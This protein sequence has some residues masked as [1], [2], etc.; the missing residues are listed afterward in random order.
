[1][2]KSTSIAN[3]LS[4][5][6]TNG[7][8]IVLD[9]AL[10]TYLELLG[11]DIS[12]SL[13]S[14]DILIKNPS[15]IKQAHLD[16]FRAGANIAIT[17]SYQASLPGL[18]KHLGDNE[19]QVKYL[20]GRSVELANDARNAYVD[21]IIAEVSEKKK[22]KITENGG[23]MATYKESIRCNLFIAGS[24]GPYG[25]FLA[26][27]SEYRGNYHV[28]KDDMKAFHRGRM[29]ELIHAGVDVLAIETIPSR[30]ETEALIELLQEEF[31]ETE[32]WFAFTLRDGEHIADGTGLV[33]MAALFDDVQQVV[34]LGFNCVPDDLAL[35]ALKVLAPR[36]RREILVV[37]PNSGEQWNAEAREWEGDRTEGC[38]L[39][40]KTVQ[41][42]HA[43]ARLI[44]GC[45][46]T[47]PG[48]IKIMR[49]SLQP[50]R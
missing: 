27:G 12:G 47:T 30:A 38:T 45:C 46:R 29:Q 48:D 44:G 28:P 24:V 5:H 32:A 23:T 33:E 43:G 7:S 16:Y 20:V 26:D 9:G 34:A 22:F 1:M 50:F 21:E 13:W 49:E 25:A 2:S 11:A 35:T 42:W 10:A 31:P 19:E 37:Y 15:L 41:W 36:I 3:K 6:L 18:A 40:D 4:T 39:A 14:A 8:P 17:A